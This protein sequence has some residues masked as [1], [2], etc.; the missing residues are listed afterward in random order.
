[1]KPLKYA[2]KNEWYIFILLS[3]PFLAAPFIWH[4]LPAQI[5]THF[6]LQGQA[7]GYSS[8]TFGLIFIPLLNIGIYL[9]LLYLPQIDPKKRITIDQKPIPVVRLIIVLFLFCIHGSIILNALGYE[10][11]STNWALVAAAIFFI[12]L[13]N[14]MR[15]IQPNYFIGIRVP[16]TLEDPK[17]WRQTH[18]MASWLWVAGGLI[19]LLLFPFLGAQL[20]FNFFMAIAVAISLLPCAYSFYLYKTKS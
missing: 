3:I 2:L 19:L 11:G 8:K 9:F 4:Q 1:M 20:Y 6:D 16:W 15:T 18:K 13:G 17:N 14:Y 10:I 7:N 12:I 5:A